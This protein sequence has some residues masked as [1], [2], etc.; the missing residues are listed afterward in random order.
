[1]KQD[2]TLGEY[3]CTEREVRALYRSMAVQLRL[4]DCARH[5]KRISGDAFTAAMKRETAAVEKCERLDALLR[6]ALRSWTLELPVR[7]PLAASIL[8]ETGDLPPICG[9]CHGKG[10]MT[11]NGIGATVAAPD[12]RD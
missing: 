7:D 10:C 3:T 6:E 11:C 5:D 1:M 12:P 9:D 2:A 8:R 4:A